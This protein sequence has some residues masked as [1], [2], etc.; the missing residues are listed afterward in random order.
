M[1]PDS[2]IKV[3]WKKTSRGDKKPIT[4]LFQTRRGKEEP[5][6]L[7]KISLAWHT[8]GGN[9]RGKK[10]QTQA[11]VGHRENGE[12]EVLPK[13]KW[14]RKC[15]SYYRGKTKR[16]K[17]RNAT[18]RYIEKWGGKL[19]LKNYGERENTYDNGLQNIWEREIR[20]PYG[21]KEKRGGNSIKRQALREK[22]RST[23]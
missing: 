16:I 7:V 23:V 21:R 10:R 12:I 2:E 15:L 19:G 6:L 3:K 20:L 5:L 22:R 4:E 14:C 11:K 8:L 1:V 13:A 9:I 18:Q 17:R